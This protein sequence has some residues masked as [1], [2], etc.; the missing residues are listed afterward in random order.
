MDAQVR[1]PPAPR[2]EGR[3]NDALAV[4][5]SELDRLYRAPP[6]ITWADNPRTARLLTAGLRKV[7]QK[8][9]E[10]AAEVALEAVRKREGATVRESADLLYHLVVLWYELGI[11]PDDVWAE[12]QTPRGVPQHRR[13]A[14]EAARKR[15]CRNS[16]ELHMHD[17][18]PTAR[19]QIELASNAPAS[20]VRAVRLLDRREPAVL[21]DREAETLTWAARGKTSSEI[22]I[23]L[24]LCKR[25]VDFHI[26][27]ARLK[28]SATSRIHA[29]A[30]ATARQLI[31]V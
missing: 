30:K 15:I 18:P 22:A 4:N 17:I 28:L 3:P 12:I 11:W 24:G 16:T 20:L 31:E 29:V 25:T 14:A 8:V 5:V 2:A 10:E 26:D 9:V 27:N 7:S 19:E 21:T 13:E 6:G 1:L 23:I